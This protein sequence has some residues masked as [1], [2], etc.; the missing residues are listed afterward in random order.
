M[1]DPQDPNRMESKIGGA[2]SPETWISIALLALVIV[3]GLLYFSIN[4]RSD[5]ASNPA[6][7][8]QE[9]PSTTGSA[10]SR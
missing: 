5:L 3:G 1:S 6:T 9:A 4:P 7:T 8:G 10:P 2:L